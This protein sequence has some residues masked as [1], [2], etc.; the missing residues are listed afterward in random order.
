MSSIS[1]S[2]IVAFGVAA[3]A[4]IG[5]LLASAQFHFGKEAVISDLRQEN[6]RLQRAV[7]EAADSDRGI[8]GIF[9]RAHQAGE[10]VR[11]LCSE[12]VDNRF[13]FSPRIG[14]RTEQVIQYFAVTTDP[15]DLEAAH[16]LLDVFAER[17][18]T[19]IAESFLD[20]SDA[21]ATFYP[22]D[23]VLRTSNFTS[24]Y[25]NKLLNILETIDSYDNNPPSSMENNAIVWRL[26]PDSLALEHQ[27]IDVND[28]V[29]RSGDQLQYAH[30]LNISP[31]CR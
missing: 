19:I 9:A 7:G 3:G 28:P 10:A 2:S 13:S 31:M 17:N 29:W 18:I 6:E 23:R 12:A 22:E 4:V 27:T 16:N 26:A 14:H 20:R 1:T 8:L 21:F 24:F 5:S 11:A 30:P 25:S 15:A